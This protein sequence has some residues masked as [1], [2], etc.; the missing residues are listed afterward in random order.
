MYNTYCCDVQREQPILVGLMKSMVGHSEG[1]S[2]M[3]SLVKL[4]LAY[5]REMIPANLHLN[6]IKSTIKPFCPPLLPVIENCEYTPGN[7]HSNFILTPELPKRP[8]FRG[9]RGG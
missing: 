1:A 7:L 9:Y 4:L 2:G 5:E 3:S 6:E 8:R